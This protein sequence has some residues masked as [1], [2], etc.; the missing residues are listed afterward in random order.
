L[1]KLV[2]C[3]F[4]QIHFKKHLKKIQ[5]FSD[6][7]L[8]NIKNESIP[9]MIT[10]MIIVIQEV[11][12]NF[13]INF[14]ISSSS[15]L[16]DLKLLK[17]YILMGWKHIKKSGNAYQQRAINLKVRVNSYYNLRII[18]QLTVF[19]HIN[20]NY[21]QY[22]FWDLRKVLKAILRKLESIK[23]EMFDRSNCLIW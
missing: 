20:S 21:E 19:K 4:I 7:K 12:L 14:F 22:R 3:L 11:R 23:L 5:F 15:R 17:D 9:A 1:L 2:L 10:V 8:V 18:I 13:N 6:H 16:T